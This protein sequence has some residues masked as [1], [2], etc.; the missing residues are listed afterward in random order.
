MNEEQEQKI[1]KHLN[2]IRQSIKD[3]TPYIE[4][5]AGVDGWMRNAGYDILTVSEMVKKSN[6]EEEEEDGKEEKEESK[7]KVVRYI[8]EEQES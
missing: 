5:I 8:D 7:E 3:I 1:L 2:Q 4:H 6:Q